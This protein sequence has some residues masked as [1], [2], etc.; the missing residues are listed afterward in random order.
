M[1]IFLV[2]SNRGNNRAR[3]A[4]GFV[5]AAL[6]AFFASGV[7]ARGFRAFS[8]LSPLLPNGNSDNAAVVAANPGSVTTEIPRAEVAKALSQ[9][10]A[11]WNTPAMQASLSERFFDAEKFGDTVSENLPR[12]AVLRIQAIRG[13][14]TLS[15]QTQQ[16]PL[17]GAVR[18]VSIVSVTAQTQL[19]FNS[20]TLGF[21]R[22]PGVNEFILEISQTV[23]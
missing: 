21:V 22:R 9:V 11:Q 14:Q 15:Q 4:I 6:C 1:S 20:P 5:V 19:E 3:Y 10:I 23:P 16:D 8:P 17:T 12:D 7:D 13:V 18:D 2:S